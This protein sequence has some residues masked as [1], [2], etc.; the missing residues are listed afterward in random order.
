M[1]RRSVQEI[2]GQVEKPAEYGKKGVCATKKKLWR[3]RGVVHRVKSQKR[4][5]RKSFNSANAPSFTGLKQ[6]VV[7]ILIRNF[8]GVFCTHAY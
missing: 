5:W 1:V 8:K 6:V 3:N 7:L 2:L 4:S